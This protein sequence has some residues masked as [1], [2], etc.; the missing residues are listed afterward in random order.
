MVVS[1][2]GVRS[3]F[4]MRKPPLITP[5]KSPVIGFVLPENR[6]TRTPWSTLSRSSRAVAPGANDKQLA[7][8]EG[9][10]EAPPAACPVDALPT[11]DVV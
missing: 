11:E 1:S 5:E 3:P 10:L 8:T 4:R 6:V 2:I 7:P 9:V